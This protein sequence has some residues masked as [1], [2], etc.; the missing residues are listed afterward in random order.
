MLWQ[1]GFLFYTG[2]VVPAGTAEFGSFEQGRVTRIVTTWMNGLGVA[3][4]LLMAWD[5]WATRPARGRWVMWVL[6]TS[7]L[8]GLLV[9]HP[10]IEG[11]IDFKG[12][13]KIHDYAGF[14]LRHR[15]YL[16]V[17]TVQWAVG[18]VYILLMLRAWRRPVPSREG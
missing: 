6:M 14:Y 3:A 11:R 2:V 4:L 5:Q 18:V 16:W 15:I 1:G 12:E 8:V 10:M 7:G 9:L 13:G 17:S